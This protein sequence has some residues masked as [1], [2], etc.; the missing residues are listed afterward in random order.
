MLRAHPIFSKIFKMIKKNL[1]GKIYHIEGEYNYGRLYKITHGWRGR[2]PF[3]SVT[4]GGGI[5][6]I[7]LVH[8]Y[9]NLKIKIRTI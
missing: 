6:I 3:Y 9:L 4:Q 5:H 8:W 2:L 1:I 7:D